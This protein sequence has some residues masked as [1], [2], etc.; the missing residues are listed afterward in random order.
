[1]KIQQE[2]EGGQREPGDSILPERQ[3][4][5]NHKV[6]IGTVKKAVLNLV[7]EGYLY[8]IQ[9]KG[10]FVAGT[11][12]RRDNLRYYRYMSSFDSPEAALKINFKD[13]QKVEGQKSINKLLKIPNSQGLY[14]LRRSLTSN[15]G[16]LIYAVSYLPQKL[17]PNLDEW[18][19]TKFER[20]PIFISLEQ[21]YGLPTIFNR[22]LF[23]I[24]SADKEVAESLDVKKGTTV[25]VI[26]M[27][28]FTYKEKPYEYRKSYC[29]TNSEKVFRE[30]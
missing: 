3:L 29:L 5:E 22:E 30:W 17:F 28:A 24:S 4:A 8:R 9:G 19:P 27:Q 26:E 25:L 23:S 10:T 11:N 18:S 6:S 2:I 7:N 15:N 1:M 20:I 21:S 12:L 13:M 16:P 14:K